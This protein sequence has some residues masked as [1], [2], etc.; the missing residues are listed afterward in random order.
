MTRGP[1]TPSFRFTAPIATLL[2]ALVLIAGCGGSSPSPTSTNKTSTTGPTTTKTTT[3]GKKKVAKVLVKESI[4]LSGSKTPAA[5]AAVAPGAALSFTTRAPGTPTLTSKV[6][7]TLTLG[8]AKKLTVVA[9]A[10]GHTS[11]ATLTSSNGKPVTL[12]DVRYL[13]LFPPKP[14][15]CPLSK[16]GGSGK[17][18]TVQVRAHGGAVLALSAAVGPVPGAKPIRPVSTSGPVVPAYQLK[19]LVRA[20]T[21]TTTG[22]AAKP[23][24]PGATVS[25]KPGDIVSFF[26]RAL[27]TA[28]AP[29]PLT[30]KFGDG[31]SKSILVTAIVPGGKTAQA[32]IT[33]ATGKPIS[34][35]LPR[36]LCFLPP[37]PTF[38]PVSKISAKTSA[39]SV[40]LPITPSSPAVEIIATAS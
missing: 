2:V 32:T 18:D 33:S 37:T 31:P 36:F 25:V 40:T 5:T 38:C 3:T 20:V 14:S 12:A 17:Q 6:T 7:V 28:G 27:G 9:S 4:V 10:R 29:Q 15:P 23:A 19:E 16:V 8:P 22:A 21:P 24:L 13:C 26:T 30:I 34:L 11:T 1:G 39:Y 35:L